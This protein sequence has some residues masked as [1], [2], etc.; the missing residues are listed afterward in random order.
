MIVSLLLAAGLA[1]APPRV[2]AE[3][4]R[5]VPPGCPAEGVLMTHN[6]DPVLLLRPQDRRGDH[7][8]RS[9]KSMPPANQELTVAR[10]VGGCA[11]STV[12]RENAQG[13]GRFAK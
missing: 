11:V 8:G 9:L 2:T 10:S 13:D 7:G 1:A 12:V 6:A 5:I 3:A 4:G